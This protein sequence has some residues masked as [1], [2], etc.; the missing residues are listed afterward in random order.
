M[1]LQVRRPTGY[2]DKSIR[3]SDR[4]NRRLTLI[5]KVI[6]IAGALLELLKG[7]WLAAIATLGVVII[8]F[9]PVALGQRF[10]VRIPPEF[11]L[12]AVIFVYASLFLGEVH[13]YYL[14]YWWWDS[15]LHTS[16]GLL[17]GI[18]G[19]LLVYVMNEKEDLQFS[20]KPSFVALFAFAF[21][22]AMGVLWEIIEFAADQTFGTNMQKSGLIDTM[23]DLIVDGLGAFTIAI[24]GYGYLSTAGSESFLERWIHHFII[25]NQRFFPDKHPDQVPA[26][27]TRKVRQPSRREGR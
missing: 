11:E 6:L 22:L 15:L 19:F 18:F 2:T 17:L 21:A 26:N 12:L 3:I 23:W 7:D 16:S 24:L 14:K 13:G 5:L 25:V 10:N 4:F 1:T 9:L 8:T 27:A 20:L